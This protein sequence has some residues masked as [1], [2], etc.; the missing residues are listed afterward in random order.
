MSI[1]IG[2]ADAGTGIDLK[3]F[4]SSLLDLDYD[5]PTSTNSAP[6]IDSGFSSSDPT[7]T[8]SPT[9]YNFDEYL[10][11]LFSSV[12]A[13][14]EVNRLYNSAEAKANRDFQS[15]EALL[16]REWYENMSNSAYQRAVTDMKA[17]GINPILAYQQG[18]AASSGTGVASGS[19][20]SYNVGGGDTISSVLNSVANLIS[21]FTSSASSLSKFLGKS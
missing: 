13:E 18:G 10:E 19:A 12:G 2:A 14:N 21:S 4:F 11:G 5:D 17:A 6:T 7:V 8:D 3:R 20:A 1:R 16:Q 15:H 9:D